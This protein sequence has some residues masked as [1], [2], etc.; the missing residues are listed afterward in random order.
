MI[1]NSTIITLFSSEATEQYIKDIFSVLSLPRG[2]R[3][4]F[5]YQSDY[6]D[7]KV[8]SIFDNFTA[9]DTIRAIIT[10]CS[11][12][13]SD[14][15]SFYIPIRW[16]TIDS[17]EK[18]SNAYIVGFYICGYPEY[19]SD[20]KNESRSFEGINR[21]TINFFQNINRSKYAVW[22]EPL[23][24]VETIDSC[25]REK[26]NWFEIVSRL[27]LVSGYEDYYFFR[28]SS[29]YSKSVGKNKLKKSKCKKQGNL[30]IIEYGKSAY[31]DIEFFSKKYDNKKKRQISVFVD[32]N[33]LSKTQGLKTSLQSRYG[34]IKLGFQTK[35]VATN[36][37]T[38][39]VI[40]TGALDEFQTE[41]IL[42]VI[43][44]KKIYKRIFK[45]LV[46][47]V[48]ALFIALPAILINLLSAKW[49]IVFAAIGVLIMAINSFWDSK[50]D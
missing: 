4:E 34:S 6:I 50:G 37:I 24:I 17:V 36:T 35:K 29:L 23:T 43:I 5:R 38:E 44:V 19:S 45:S 9:K 16:V 14:E 8:I 21:N 12:N 22:G 47:A 7:P 13:K 2:S 33:K 3:F 28:C 42:P 1:N 30:F 26:E 49:N 41:I 10:F 25:E 20:F 46:T 18:L 27:T 40:N 31:I 11:D 39:I 32:D 15:K 48:G